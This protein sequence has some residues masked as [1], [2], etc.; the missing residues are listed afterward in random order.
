VIPTGQEEE[1]RGLFADEARTQL[2]RIS[3]HVLALE[4]DAADPALLAT[5]FRDAHTLKGAAAVVGCEEVAAVAHV[6]EDI[7]DA[8]RAGR[9]AWDSALVDAALTAVDAVRAMVDGLMADERRA[10]LVAPTVA[11]LEQALAAERPSEPVAPPPPALPDPAPEAA[12]QPEPELPS[13]TEPVPTAAPRAAAAPEGEIVRVPRERLEELIRLAGQSSAAQLRVGQI[14]RER[15]GVEPESLSEYRELSSVLAELGSRAMRSRMVTLGTIAAPLRRA[16]R[17]V[18]R[19]TGKQVRLEL[20]GDAVELDR[21]VLEELRDPLLHLV[22]NAVD[23]GLEAPDERASAGKPAEGLIRLSARRAGSQLVIS[24]SDDGRGVDLA[25]LRAQS[26]VELSEEQ[27]LALMF[28]AG[29]S[30]AASLTDISGRGVGLDIV[31]ERL[32]ELRGRI[33]VV[34]RPGDGLTFLLHVPVTLSILPCLMVSGAGQRFA[35]PLDDLDMVLEEGPSAELSIEGRR[36]IWAGSEPVEISS[37]ATLLGRPGAA[38]T[39]PAVVLACEG[40]RYAVRVDELLGQRDAIIREISPIVGHLDALA[41]AT[42]EPDGSITLVLDAGGLIARG[43]RAPARGSAQA[44]VVAATPVAA[45]AP[46]AQA[47]LLV[48]DDAL[49]VRELQRTILVRAGYDV[50]VASNGRE[51]LGL[52]AAA[53]ADLVLSDYEMPEM[54]GFALCRAIRAHPRLASIPVIVLTSRDGDDSRRAGLEAGADAYLIKSEFDEATLLAAVR[55][56]LG[57]HVELAA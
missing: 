42:V 17:D 1:F 2:A 48:V 28:R 54:D 24:V 53:P 56:L 20:E 55:R 40:E 41:G 11:V 19:A 3:E 35:I 22:R 14:I 10:D 18:A 12:P 36:A 49:T 30:T 15:A 29:T 23:H 16:V 7:F 21:H 8:V 5:L 50:R 44:L 33:E 39:G 13:V 25:A 27:A 51:A 47:S 26:D 31:T 46:P 9:R 34:N 38:C 6:L 37:L 4:A 43:L 32:S 52:L 45:A 57:S